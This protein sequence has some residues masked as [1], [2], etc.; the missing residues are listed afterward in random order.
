M[1]L[2]REIYDLALKYNDYIIHCRRTVHQNPEL[3]MQEFETAA[4]IRNELDKM[5]I[6]W[7][8]VG[9]TG[10]LGTLPATGNDGCVVALRADIDALPINEDTGLPYAS[11]NPGRM[12]ACGHDGHVSML[13]GAAK[14]LSSLKERPNTVKLLFQPAEEV[15]RGAGLM[16]DGGALRGVDVIYGSHLWPDIPTGQ[17]GLRDG[18]AMAGADKYLIRITGRG[19]HGSEPQSCADP[20]PA[21]TSIVDAIHQIK[22]LSLRGDTPMVLTVG[23]IRCGTTMNIIPES[24][25]V[26]GTIRWFDES[27]RQ[28]AH[29]RIHRIAECSSAMY[30]CRAET[31][32]TGLCPCT[33]NTPEAAE[34]ARRILASMCGEAAVST[35]FRLSFVSEDFS[36]Y[37]DRIP[38]VFG[39]VGCGGSE[40][41]YGLHSAHFTPDEAAL[42][43]G[44]AVY[45]AFAAGYKKPL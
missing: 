21:C 14:I 35:D 42:K 9:E 27:S 8:A 23:Y 33:V 15:G 37:C 44:S 5:G 17:I 36:F 4:F 22:S 30:D 10:T 25:E 26:C 24:G 28:L 12:H 1:G 41:H 16:I 45:A 11:K 29:E 39:F 2:Y 34:Q 18:Y 13:I 32:F 40:E 19:G 43:L 20:I 31:E 6:L 38:S 7:E 3:S